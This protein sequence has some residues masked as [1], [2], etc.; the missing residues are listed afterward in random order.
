MNEKE[1]FENRG[2][3]TIDNINDIEKPI[4]TSTIKSG[5]T[6]NCNN[7]NNGGPKPYENSS[8]MQIQSE[9]ISKLP[10]L[11]E[12]SNYT[13]LDYDL[14]EL[15]F[16]ETFCFMTGVDLLSKRRI[17]SCNLVDCVL[18]NSAV[19]SDISNL[20]I[21]DS[22]TSRS[23]SGYSNDFVNIKM[24]KN[25]ECLIKS[26][27][28]QYSRGFYNQ[29]K[30]GGFG[31]FMPSNRIRLLSVSE[32]AKNGGS[33]TVDPTPSLRMGEIRFK[34]YEKGGLYLTDFSKIPKQQGGFMAKIKDKF[35]KMFKNP[36][37]SNYGYDLPV[38][39]SQEELVQRLSEEDYEK[40]FGNVFNLDS[41]EIK[42][43]TQGKDVAEYLKE[44]DN[45]TTETKDTRKVS[46]K[47]QKYLQNKIK[48]LATMKLKSE[49][50]KANTLAKRLRL[51]QRCGHMHLEGIS[52]DCQECKIA[53]SYGSATHEKTRKMRALSFNE[54][55]CLDYTGP[56]PESIDQ[57]RV[58][59]IFKD[60]A[61]GICEAYPLRQKSNIVFAVKDWLNTHGPPNKFRSDNAPEFKGAHSPYV[62]FIK[63]QKPE[64]ITIE[65]SSPYNPQENSQVERE[66]RSVCDCIRANCMGTDPRLWSYAARFWAYVQNRLPKRKG[67][68]PFYLKNGYESNIK[69]M[70]RF[71]TLCYAKVL[72]KAPTKMEDR[73]VRSIFLGYSSKNNCYLVGSYKPD[74][75]SRELNDFKVTECKSVK[76]SEDVQINRIEDLKSKSCGTWVKFKEHSQLKLSEF[77]DDV[78]TEILDKSKGISVLNGG[79][80]RNS[81][82]N[83]PGIRSPGLITGDH[84]GSGEGR[85]SPQD[86]HLSLIHI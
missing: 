72:G 19:N 59:A 14:D 32:F 26:A 51:H 5:A 20:W 45:P 80:S 58:L 10:P 63:K 62:L 68:S 70:K 17:Y 41:K 46:T 33:F 52:V 64:N 23:I 42:E 24:E 13:Y 21:V 71:G 57:E 7:W 44:Y 79:D 3:C 81:M 74:G 84:G 82:P 83:L 2:G 85:F 43:T 6:V 37:K 55:V 1:D 11:V 67:D 56:F 34:V 18:S 16:I 50:A 8:R 30:S 69:H 86:V 28:G 76:F 75:R 4:K 49:I 38:G 22:G 53:K 36:F 77:D 40:L 15:K 25:N 73:Y 47:S 27:N 9:V 65:Y 60:E 29:L 31:I 35:G 54:R 61:T 39:G 48:N 12:N 78:E 66:M